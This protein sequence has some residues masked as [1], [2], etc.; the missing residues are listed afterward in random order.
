MRCENTSLYITATKT[1]ETPNKILIAR[2]KPLQ[3]TSSTDGN[4]TKTKTLNL[5]IKTLLLLTTTGL[6]SSL[7]FKY[8]ISTTQKPKRMTLFNGTQLLLV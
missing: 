1:A 7:Q 8:I 6:S 5:F 3:L 4:D 2:S